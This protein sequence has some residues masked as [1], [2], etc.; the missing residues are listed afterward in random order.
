MKASFEPRGGWRAAGW[1]GSGYEPAI[2]K[3]TN[4][5]KQATLNSRTD[6]PKTDS[7]RLGVGVAKANAGFRNARTRV[8]DVSKKGYSP[9]KG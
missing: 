5:T 7:K 9:R 8:Y 3:Y 2:H 1:Y 4:T 6:E